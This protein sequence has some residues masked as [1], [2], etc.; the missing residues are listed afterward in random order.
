M[1]NYFDI[2]VVFDKE[3]NFKKFSTQD[4]L[5]NMENGTFEAYLL[6]KNHI[7]G[8]IKHLRNE[9]KKSNFLYKL[10]FLF[11]KG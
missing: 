2:Y 3:N 9:V 8:V 4:Q 10:K 7:S 1:D 6:N 11:G 5:L